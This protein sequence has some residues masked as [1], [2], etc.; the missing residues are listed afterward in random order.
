MLADNGN[1]TCGEFEIAVWTASDNIC[2]AR[3]Q[4]IQLARDVCCKSGAVSMAIYFGMGWI[5]AAIG[6]LWSIQ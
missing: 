4:T 1:V 2:E 5:A 3:D 6:I